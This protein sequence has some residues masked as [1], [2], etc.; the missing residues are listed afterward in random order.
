MIAGTSRPRLASKVRLRLDRHSGQHM[1]L[2]PER[3]LALN[4]TAAV[5]AELCTGAHSVAA[6]IDLLAARFATT[7]R[8]VIEHEALAFLQAMRERGLIE[9][10]G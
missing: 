5:V 7:S 1:L 10:E 9:D 6:I 8:D 2:Y 4:E 3:G